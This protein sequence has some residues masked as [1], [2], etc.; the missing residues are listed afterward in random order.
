MVFIALCIV[1]IL[2]ATLSFYMWIK[3][4]KPIISKDD[5]SKRLL[6]LNDYPIVGASLRFMGNGEGR[7]ISLH[8]S[9]GLFVISFL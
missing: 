9:T 7:L 4:N 6:R 8:F 1:F 2:A 3:Q 5:H